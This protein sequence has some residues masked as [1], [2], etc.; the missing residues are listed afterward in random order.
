[1]QAASRPAAPEEVRDVP[2]ARPVQPRSDF[3]ESA[4]L[5]ALPI[6]AA[7][8]GVTS[9]GVL[10]LIERNRKF[11]EVIAQ[12]GDAAMQGG[13]F[14]QCMH[15]QIAHLMTAFLAD[16][17]APNE[18]DFC[19]GEGL[20]SRHFRIKLAPLQRD[21]ERDRPRC[22]VCLV[23]R[24]VEVQAE[25]T[26]RS[27]M[28][29]DSLTGLPNRLSFTESLEAADL[30]DRSRSHHA[31]LVVDMRRFSRINES[32][33]SMAGDELL[34]TFARRLMSALRTGDVL[35]R[36]GGNEFGILVGLKRG[37]EDAL[38]AAERIQDMM[39]TPFKL[40]ELEIRVECAIGVALMDSGQ[41]PEELFRHAQF[42]VK[43][44]KAVGKPQVYEPREASAAR[45]RFSIETELR[46]A[47][48]KDQLKLFY[49]PLINLKSGEVAGFEALARWTHEDRGE[50]SPVEFIPV[51][52]ES[53]LILTLG[54]WA[55]DKATQTLAE[56]D[57]AAG[58]PLPAYVA[59]N[60]SAI[61][62]ARDDIADV[63]ESAL[64]SSGLEGKRLTLELTESSIVQDPARATRVF[65]ALKALD[66]TVAMDDFGTG[67]SSLAYLQRLPIDVLKIDRSFVSGMMSDP[68]SIAIVRAVLSLAEALGMSTTA[69]G[70]ETVELATTLAALGCRSGQGYFFAKPLDPDAAFEYLKA[71]RR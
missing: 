41:D 71:R 24:T 12:S 1:M 3:D 26:L 42:A 57:R 44:A 6:A 50:I 22:L 61:Q 46:R 28:L 48:D 17:T 27:E 25:R 37:V 19:D 53:G 5:T 8:V 31:V 13:D 60:L 10:K 11:D 35:S 68:D 64:R 16:F 47:L 18:L 29:R 55:M 45:R 51:A 40:S 14:R 54:R 20:G 59:V 63:V 36:T 9:T 62:I 4:L 2:P 69:E 23:D 34:I 33:G 32:M 21:E 49:Q 67:Y 43:Q 7:I 30:G 38:A 39:T 66:T 52:E 70:V 56:W 15:V 58:A 65:D